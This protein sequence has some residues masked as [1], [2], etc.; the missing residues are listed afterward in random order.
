MQFDHALAVGGVLRVMCDLHDRGAFAVQ[1]SQQRH[2]H[3]TLRRMQR[4]GRLI[5]QQQLWSRNHGNERQ[6][7]AAV[8]RLTTGADIGLSMLIL[9]G[10]NSAE[11][12]NLVFQ[13]C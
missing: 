1:L 10:D 2:D 6:Q 13:S 3:L 11:R 9:S 5:R 4:T 8:G 12:A 7:R